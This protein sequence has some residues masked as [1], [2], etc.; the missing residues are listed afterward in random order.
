[1]NQGVLGAFHD[2]VAVPATSSRSDSRSRKSRS[3]SRSRSRTR[4]ERREREQGPR[5]ATMLSSAA[6]K[7]QAHTIKDRYFMPAR[8]ENKIGQGTYGS[9]FVA[10]RRRKQQMGKVEVPRKGEPVAIK[11]LHLEREKEGFPVTSVREIALLQLSQ[12][13]HAQALKS[14]QQSRHSLQTLPSQEPVVSLRDVCALER[15]LRQPSAPRDVF[16]VFEKCDHDLRGLILNRRNFGDQ[17]RTNRAWQ[18]WILG[19]LLESLQV[20]H[21]ECGV[22]HRDVKSANILVKNNGAVRL[23]DLGLARQYL[24]DPFRRLRELDRTGAC[25]DEDKDLED[26][27]KTPNVVT[28]WYRAPELLLHE[29]CYGSGIDIWSAGCV[30]AEMILGKPLFGEPTEVRALSAIVEL[31]GL[32]NDDAWPTEGESFEKLCERHYSLTP[33]APDRPTF[34]AVFDSVD[35]DA[36]DLLRKLLAL[37]PRRRMSAREALQHAFFKRVL[38][39]SGSLH[40]L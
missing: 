13:R 12:A 20:L 4:R 22:L 25:K 30:F 36:K 40:S 38:S 9:V 2:D 27:R 34:D 17:L 6:A 11:Q 39:H 24:R 5:D 28:L 15:T 10:H 31:L 23:A 26:A 32:P 3:R 16:L 35:A 33:R 37:H 19:A 14:Q 18:K 7:W 21:D 1:M 8:G 29:R